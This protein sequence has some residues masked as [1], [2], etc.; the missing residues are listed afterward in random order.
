MDINLKGIF[1]TDL[2]V[3]NN[4]WWSTDKIDKINNN[5]Y[6]LAMGG[7]PGPPGYTGDDGFFGSPGSSGSGGIQG[8]QGI[9]GNKGISGVNEW[10]NI[11][12]DASNYLYLRKNSISDVET[13]PTSM[14]IGFLSGSEVYNIPSYWSDLPVQIINIEPL[15]EGD[16]TKTSHLRLDNRGISD[17]NEGFDLRLEGIEGNEIH[18]VPSLPFNQQ[19]SEYTLQWV[20]KNTVFRTGDIDA[21]SI[22]ADLIK[23]GDPTI[24]VVHLSNNESNAGFRYNVESN[25]GDILVS[26]GV[27]G[28]VEWKNK[29]DISTAFPI[30]SIVSI[31][32][33]DFINSFS[34]DQVGL[35]QVGLPILNNIYGRGKVNTMFAGWYLCNGETWE[36]TEG[37]NR[38]K[39]PNLNRFN[40]DIGSNGGSQIHVETENNNHAIIG[41][42]NLSMNALVTPEGSYNIEFNNEF[43]D[44]NHDFDGDLL[45]SDS[46]VPPATHYI[47]KM[48][49]IVYLDDE[50]L[51]WSNNEVI[52]PLIPT[53]PIL[54]TT[55]LSTSSLTCSSQANITYS[56]TNLHGSGEWNVFNIL[57]DLHKLFI[58]GTNTYA[59]IGWYKNTAGYPIYWNGTAFSQRGVRC[60]IDL[61]FD[62][63]VENLN[64]PDDL[65]SNVMNITTGSTFQTTSI[66]RYNATGLNAAA[67]WYRDMLTGVRRYWDGGYFVGVSFSLNYVF[68]VTLDNLN[69]SNPEYSS[70]SQQVEIIDEEPLY[71]ECI[72]NRTSHI[73]YIET[74][75]IAFPTTSGGGPSLTNLDYIKIYNHILYVAISW[76]NPDGYSPP[77]INIKDQF[78]PSSSSIRYNS[79]VMGT[80]NTYGTII[81][82]SNRTGRVD[83]ISTC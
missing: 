34:L 6:Q 54:L 69:V 76:V 48:V 57:T 26:N 24:P 60:V 78:I 11:A 42:Y 43:L 27:A 19:N 68:R 9:R 81:V 82:A 5:F 49:H 25:V 80:D 44:N 2:D 64:F 13:W 33:N 15:G 75:D 83:N 51:K 70:D 16:V 12:A 79:V 77:L 17:E 65:V 10:L 8:L 56:W 67:G 32:E 23:V 63:Y 30:G 31:S 29:I 39:T 41:G 66:L 3:N 22:N 28:H 35:I 45:T 52:V 61:V 58:F 36:T 59:P 14:R 72:I 18:I 20:S 7:M 71:S 38:T 62:S 73:T 74:A 37:T 21:L 47:S 46:F 4:T 40:Y 50:N 1:I 53:I 55:N